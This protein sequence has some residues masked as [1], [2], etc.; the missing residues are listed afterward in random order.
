MAQA[1][2]ARKRLQN[3]DQ[4][5]IPVAEVNRTVP[6]FKPA[7]AGSVVQGNSK[8]ASRETRMSRSCRGRGT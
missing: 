3:G 5:W 6:G 4:V 7:H 1:R 8:V 2:V